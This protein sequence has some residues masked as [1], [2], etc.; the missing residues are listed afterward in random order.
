MSSQVSETSIYEQHPYFFKDSEIFYPESDGEPMAETDFHIN[1]ITYLRTALEN[2]FANRADVYVTGNIMFYYLEG[3][4]NE[5]VS[6]DVMVCFGAP[7]GNRRTYKVWEEN[8][9]VPSVIFEIASRKTWVKDRNE[10]RE[11]YELLGVQEYYIFNPEY[12]KRIPAFLAH[13][14]K[15]GKLESV[16]VENGFVHSEI[17]GLDVIDTGETLRLLDPKTNQ[18]LPTVEELASENAALKAE[19]EKLKKLLRNSE[20]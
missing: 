7:K 8:E 5:V 18:F 12:P 15:N 2:F 9:V 3:A 4:P 14:L 16:T 10:K 6:P 11:L 17:L 19:L 1:L 13:K 20:S